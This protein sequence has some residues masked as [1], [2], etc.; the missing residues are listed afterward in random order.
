MKYAPMKTLLIIAIGFL[1]PVCAFASPQESKQE[2]EK[3]KQANVDINQRIDNAV[4]YLL[5]KQHANG[6]FS[7][8]A[9]PSAKDLEKWRNDFR[10]GKAHSLRHSTAFTSLA[11]LSLA[12][13]GHQPGDPT[14]EGRAMSRAIDFVVEDRLVDENGYFGKADHSRM[15]G[16]GITTLM[17]TEMLGMGASDEQDRKI[18]LRA[19]AALDLILKAQAI[20]KSPKHAGGWR[21]TPNANDSDLSVTVWQLMAL[22]SARN[23]GFTVP[24]TSIDIAIKYL[25]V[26]YKSERGKNGKP[27]NLDS[28]FCYEPGRRPEFATT[29]AGLLA[30]QVCGAYDLPEVEAASKFLMKKEVRP[31]ENRT[32]FFYGI[33]YYAQGQAQRGGEIASEARRITEELL[34]KMQK[35]DGSFEGNGQEKNPVYSTSMAILSL[36]IQ[37]HYLPIYQR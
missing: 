29:A 21:Y 15:Y 17:L 14:D 32:W 24:K 28:G 4:E 33:Y 7:T 19:E 9:D 36:S 37:H 16:H 11:I 5:S 25:Q 35:A 22:R 13:I 1:I 27:K 10:N 34:A 26:C 12:S 2:S 8:D 3:P 18:R 6:C 23:A 30:L 31:Q 20:E